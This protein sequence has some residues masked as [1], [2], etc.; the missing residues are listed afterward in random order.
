MLFLLPVNIDV[1]I[2]IIEWNSTIIFYYV[3][4]IFVCILPH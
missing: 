1:Q 2:D 3:L 4:N